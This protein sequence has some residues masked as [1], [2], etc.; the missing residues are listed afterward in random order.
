MELLA[1]LALLAIL[2]VAVISLIA[3]A[4]LWVA[5]LFLKS[6]WWAR[7]RNKPKTE[8]SA[9]Q[10]V[11]QKWSRRLWI[12]SGV[13]MVLTIIAGVLINTVF[14]ESTLRWAFNQVYDKTDMRLEF[15][16][17]DGNLFAGRIE[18][19]GVTIKRVNHPESNMDL[20]IKRLEID[21]SVLS[22]AVGA[23]V[24]EF[25]RIEELRG[26]LEY[27]AKAERLN[28]RKP[29]VLERLE[30]TDAQIR[31]VDHRPRAGKFEID[32][33]LES[34]QSSPISTLTYVFDLLF[35][36]D[37]KGSLGGSPIEVVTSRDDGFRSHWI[38]QQ[39][40]VNIAAM[41]IGQPFDWLEGGTVDVDV[42]N[43]FRDSDDEVHADWSLVLKDVSAKVPDKTSVLIRP[44]AE[45]F[46]EFVNKQPDELPLQFEMTLS[47]N[48]IEE[49]AS[50]A[51]SGLWK[52]LRG[53]ILKA[54]A[55]VA[56]FETSK[57]DDTVDKAKGILGK[58]R[59]AWKSRGD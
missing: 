34:L 52:A 9:A 26:T 4:G 17:A 6:V 45:K 30:V 31:F 51:A 12:T 10:R 49:S 46:V 21:L 29:V 59:D 7:T 28:P 5:G 55:T 37:L 8:P 1:A 39:L 24:V 56:G 25:A 40:P 58:A 43:Q 38:I 27:V 50:I 42:M 53:P 13:L 33:V 47:R 16:S 35:R 2:D 19:D 23:R 14:F 3:E 57:I 54:I 44:I 11:I 20:T 22:I 36:S 48:N 18:L 41:Y 15:E 32:L